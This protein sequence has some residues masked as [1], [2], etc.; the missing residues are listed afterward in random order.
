MLIVMASQHAHGWGTRMVRMETAA[1]LLALSILGCEHRDWPGADG[2][3]A[4]ASCDAARCEPVLTPQDG[5]TSMRKDASMIDG[6]APADDA[7]CES[8]DTDS[9]CTARDAGP[10]VSDAEP[11]GD[12][13][14]CDDVVDEVLGACAPGEDCPCVQVLATEQVNPEEMVFSDTHIYWVNHG[15]Y[16]MAHRGDG[17]LVAIPRAGGPVVTLADSLLGP[18]ELAIDGT[19]AYIAIQV[20]LFP[21]PGPGSINRVPLHGGP[22]ETLADG[23]DYDA[24]LALVD[25]YVYWTRSDGSD[26]PAIVRSP[27]DG[28]TAAEPWIVRDDLSRFIAVDADRVYWFEVGTIFAASQAGDEP[29]SLGPFAHGPYDDVAMD[30]SY[31]YWA[32]QEA[33]EAGVERIAKSGGEAVTIVRAEVG[34]TLA[35]TVDGARIFWM[36]EAPDSTLVRTELISGDSITLPALH[37]GRVL[38]VVEH[39]F[40]FSYG[41]FDEFAVARMR[42]P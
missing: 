3:A 36:Y 23:L 38:A 37:I 9:G 32:W 7:S 27:K 26:P 22:L 4:D 20:E 21:Y 30:D 40:Y 1:A 19:H 2:S 6:E 34:R 39:A 29:I 15:S 16:G 42:T 12:A 18:V 35:L 28:S 10:E 5:G 33:G 31:L 17:S 13:F 24:R 14:A 11:D 41:R 8:E 25:T